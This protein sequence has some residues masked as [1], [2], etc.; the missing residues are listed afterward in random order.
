MN[1]NFTALI[2]MVSEYFNATQECMT[3]ENSK[4]YEEYY[5]EMNVRFYMLHDMCK[6]FNINF[7]NLIIL[8]RMA[9]KYEVKHQ[10]EKI[11]TDEC[12]TNDNK[13]DITDWLT[14]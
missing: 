2:G 1:I 14:A 12:I 6:A 13:Q 5:R 3:N 9:Y 7:D 11:F 10:W 4:H 8:G